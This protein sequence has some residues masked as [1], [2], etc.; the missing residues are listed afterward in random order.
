M[1]G[2]ENRPPLTAGSSSNRSCAPGPGPGSDC[3][4]PLRSPC[5]SALRFNLPCLL[6][7]GGERRR[8][9]PAPGLGPAAGRSSASLRSW[10]ETLLPRWMA[11]THPS[12][13]VVSAKQGGACQ[14]L[15]TESVHTE[16]QPWSLM[17]VL[18]FRA[19]LGVPPETPS[20]VP[21]PTVL[22]TA[23]LSQA[24]NDLSQGST[25]ARQGQSTTSP[26]RRLGG[27]GR[28]PPSFHQLPLP[29]RQAALQHAGGHWVCRRPSPP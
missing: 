22:P 5:S 21:P 14:V 15:G 6:G 24:P 25:W 1:V 8:R 3:R 13:V 19:A 4:R 28:D 29:V 16:Y 12:F 10:F 27:R 7:M 20:A 2:P 17:P 26:K 9:V 23:L 18:K 11:M